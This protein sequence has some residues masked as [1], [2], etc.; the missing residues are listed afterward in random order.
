MKALRTAI[1]LLLLPALTV[2]TGCSR[3]TLHPILKQDIVEMKKGTSYTCDRDGYFLSKL[4]LD[5]VAQAKVER[6]R[7]K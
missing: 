3:V 4:Y 5:E 7:L 1:F 2:L 6:V